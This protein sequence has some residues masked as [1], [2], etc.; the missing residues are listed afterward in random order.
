[1]GERITVVL[2]DGVSEKL[3]E[4]AGSSRKQGEYLSRLI[5]ATYEGERLTQPDGIEI[6]T[7]R[8]QIIG[9]TSEHRA[10]AS[11]VLQLEKQLAA[12]LPEHHEAIDADTRTQ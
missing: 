3:V 1:V 6:E 12:L 11:R 5:N 7:L 2:D 4:L 9:L 8:L 10:L